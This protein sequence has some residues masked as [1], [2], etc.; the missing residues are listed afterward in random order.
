[1]FAAE[2]V[3]RLLEHSGPALKAMILLGMSCGFGN[4][5]CGNLPLATQDVDGGWVN[6]PRPKAGIHRR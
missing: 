2:E 4:A 3:R 6:Y 1:L 5:D